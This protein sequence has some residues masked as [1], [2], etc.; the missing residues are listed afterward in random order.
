MENEANRVTTAETAFEM[1]EFVAEN[2]SVGVSEVA[3]GLEAI[4]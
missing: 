4:F 2:E 1:V 3:A